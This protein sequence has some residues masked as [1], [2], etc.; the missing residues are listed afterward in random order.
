LAVGTAH[1]VGA[2]QWSP[3]AAPRSGAHPSRLD[4]RTRA[5]RSARLSRSGRQSSC[6]FGRIRRIPT[7]IENAFAKLKMLQR[8]AAARAVDDVWRVIGKCIGAFT[9]AE[10]QNH[11]PTADMTPSDRTMRM[12]ND[13]LFAGAPRYSPTPPPRLLGHTKAVAPFEATAQVTQGYIRR[14]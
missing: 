7:R 6:S 4:Q 11:L 8:K 1:R 12:Q 3:P 10:R 5:N 13:R 14:R 2:G 9:P